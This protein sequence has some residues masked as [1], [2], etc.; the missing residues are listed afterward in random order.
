MPLKLLTEDDYRGASKGAVVTD[1][2]M[3]H[4]HIAL[5]DID[6]HSRPQRC[7]VKLYP[8]LVGDREH[9]GIANEIAGYVIAK[10]MG[11]PVPSDAGLIAF[12]GSQLANLP[13]WAS[14]SSYLC[15]WW[16]RDMVSPSLKAFYSLEDLQRVPALLQQKIAALRNELLASPQINLVLAFDDLIANI[17]RNIGNLLRAKGGDYV[18]IDHGL[19]LTSDD[20]VAGDLEPSKSYHNK[21]HAMLRPEAERLPF[22]HATVRAHE[23]LVA[24]LE[25]AMAALLKWLPYAVE[26]AELAAVERFIR[27][28][29]AP[30]SVTKRWELFI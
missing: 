17:D 28:R 5:L 19:C 7:Y 9:R 30:G 18:L 2:Q 16:V 26:A 22:R 14:E 8:D 11:A 1:G 6:G 27:H 21:L 29:A 23:N 10:A 25:S 3:A 15:G 24:N 13:G 12:H 4:T 20:W